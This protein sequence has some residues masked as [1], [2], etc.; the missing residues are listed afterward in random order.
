MA[1]S[2][3]LKSY[4]YAFILGGKYFCHIWIKLNDNS[5]LLLLQQNHYCIPCYLATDKPVISLNVR[6]FNPVHT[7]KISLNKKKL[8]L[9]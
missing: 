6:I 1:L 9:K 3:D 4:N 5:L 2:I 8:N 7:S